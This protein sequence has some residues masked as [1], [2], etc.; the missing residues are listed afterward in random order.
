VASRNRHYE[1]VPFEI[2][3]SWE[4][5]K[6]GDIGTWQAGG[7]PNRGHKEYFG[8]DIPWLKTG[9]LND[10]YVTDIPEFIT[11]AGFENSSAKLNPKDSV[12][13]ALYGAT[14]G[15][16]GI[17]T[18]PATTNQACC[19]CIDYPAVDKL[20]LYYFLRQHRDV[21]ISQGGGGAQ[22]NISKEI[23]IATLIPIPPLA[24]QKRIVSEIEK[25]F[26][27]IDELE[28]ATV[29]LQENI[30]QTKNKILDLSIHGKLVSQEPNDEPASE[31]LKRIAP[32]AK[33]CDTSHY[34]NL[35]SSWCVCSIKDVFDIT[36][37]SSPSGSSL[38][39]E[40]DGVEFHQGKICFS[41]TYLE[42]SDVYT[43]MPTKL[44]EAHSILLCVRAPVGVVNITEREICI[45]RGLCALKPKTDIDFMFAYY[46]LQTHKEHFVEQASGSTFNAVRGDTIRN[47]SF[48]LPPY[49]EQIR[50]REK[51]ESVLQQL[52][53]ITAEL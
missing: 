11:H 4:W 46:A 52:N 30:E 7:T 13:I 40:K 8:G 20:F 19:A 18:F 1:N 27:L 50:I 37:G 35:P 12:L 14:I 32:D 2:P 16:V 51:I 38:N 49:N 25:W 34:G 24:E 31:L 33:P 43:N 26:V 42:E 41:D 39:K 45:G 53:E 29:D 3:E 22:P 9:D 48:I 28:N 47:E 5:Q 21:F 6:L 15:K 10:G 17:L 23:V 36:M 44:A